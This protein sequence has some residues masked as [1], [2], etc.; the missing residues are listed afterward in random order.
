MF[1][2][3]CRC[4]TSF[5]CRLGWLVSLVCIRVLILVFVYNFSNLNSCHLLIRRSIIFNQH[6]IFSGIDLDDPLLV[7]VDGLTKKVDE[8]HG[9]AIAGYLTIGVALILLALY[10]LVKIKKRFL[11]GTQPCGWLLLIV[12]IVSC[13]N[14]TFFILSL[15][16]FLCINQ[17]TWFLKILSK[18]FNI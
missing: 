1:E 6:Y 11:C 2:Y 15:E 13:Q 9:F 18:F 8:S 16:Y 4:S 12:I 10:I 17:F 3:I 5:W 14:L 7:Q